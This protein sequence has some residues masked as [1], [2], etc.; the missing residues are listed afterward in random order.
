MTMLFRTT[1]AN[2]ETIL[3]NASGGL[4]TVVGYQQQ[5]VGAT[6]ILGTKRRVQVFSSGQRFSEGE[7]GPN[8]PFQGDTD[9]AV[10][11]MVSAAATG[12][13]TVI[14]NP[15]STGPQ[16][17]AAIAAFQD[18]SKVA[19]DSMDELIDLIF[20]VLMDASNQD[21]GFTE[22]PY[23]VKNRWI[24]GWTKDDPLNHG[25]YVAL[26]ADFQ[27]QCKI[28]EEVSGLTP[29]PAEAGPI[30]VTDVIEGDT[31]KQGTRT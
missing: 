23:K 20:Q 4:Y 17:S 14:N 2:L 10:R 3:N 27:F 6:E 30:D 21:I 5:G 31:A 12:D 8:G 29:T 7:S 25:E 22:P 11:L 26:T 28:E 16:L 19:D 13:L 18:A 24:A 9:F 1:K 15:S